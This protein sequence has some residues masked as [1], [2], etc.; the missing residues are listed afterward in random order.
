MSR[1]LLFDQVRR[2]LQAASFCEQNSLSTA[3]GLA[4]LEA[5]QPIS[6]RGV[7]QGAAVVAGAALAT[8]VSS[9]AWAQSTGPRIA[10]IGGGLSGL[11]CA[12]RLRAKGYSATIYEAN[13]RVGGRVHS[14]RDTFPGQVAEL[15]GELID[16][17]HKTMLAYANEFNLL[18]EDLGKAPGE[19]TFFVGGQHYSEATVVDEFRQLVPRMRADLQSLS[20]QP[21]FFSHTAA[22]V[23]LDNVDL[24]TYLATRGAGL[25]VIQQVL[26]QAYVAEYGL[27]PSQQSCLNMLLFLHLDGSSKFREYGVFSDERYHLIGGN[28]AIATNIRARL[29]GAVNLG[30]ELTRLAKNAAGKY[31]LSFRGASSPELADSVIVTVPFSV[32]RRLTLDASL[33]LS[34][35]KVRAINTLGYGANAKTMIGFNGRPWAE[36]GGNGLVYADL[37]NV[38]T[39]WETNYSSAGATSVLTDYTGGARGLALQAPPPPLGT[40]SSCNTCHNGPAGFFDIED[41]VIQEQVAGFLT[42][43]DQVFPGAKAR[44]TQVG[45]KYVVRRGHW[46]AQRYS[47]G[48]YVCYLPGQFT[49]VAGLEGQSAGALKFAGE[50]A[51][52]FYEWQGFM[53]GACLSG[54]AAADEVLADIR[55][56]RI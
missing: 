35:D 24:G 28:D 40:T 21:T 47:R 22:D 5:K 17:L 25:P 36:Q 45:G 20:S 43:F 37:P 23:A 6:R 41:F 52:S 18:K 19:K 48:S 46:Q 56:G 38:Q 49:G 9:R 15:G 53:E 4:R 39:T 14:A 51:N 42:D 2:A 27:E 31:E 8:G 29:P 12:D 16:N 44:A 50:H 33:G 7:L 10:I 32:L 55:A 26:A 3:E 11:A 1:S 30:M 13:T 54:I 34:A